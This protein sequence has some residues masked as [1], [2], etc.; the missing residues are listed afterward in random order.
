MRDV[1][2]LRFDDVF[3]QLSEHRREGFL[4]ASETF[5]MPVQKEY[6]VMLE[7]AKEYGITWQTEKLFL[8]A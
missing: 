2:E 3:D 6:S 5:N 7:F 1:K 8:T 4:G